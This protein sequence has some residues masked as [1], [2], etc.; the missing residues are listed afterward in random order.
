MHLQYKR[1]EGEVVRIVAQ[2]VVKDPQEGALAVRPGT[3]AQET[4]L[5]AG[6]PLLQSLLTS[7]E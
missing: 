6:G 4:P 5:L 1:A 7:T 3:A 2:K